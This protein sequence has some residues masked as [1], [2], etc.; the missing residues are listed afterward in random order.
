[1]PSRWTGRALLVAATA[2]LVAGLVAPAAA[3]VPTS[4]TWAA[5]L[6]VSG[7]DDTN[8]VADGAAVRLADLTPRGTSQGP[9]PAEGE[10]LLA[11]RRPAAVTDRVAVDVTADVPPAAEVIVA[12]RGTRD[13]GTWGQWTE[14]RSGEPARLSEPTVELQ[15]RVTL[16]AAPDGRGPALQRLWLTADR[17]PA[18]LVAPRPAEPFTARVF[19]TRIGLVGNDTANGH[20]VERDDRFVALPSRRALAPRG[21]GDY[22][23][24]VCSRP[25]RC[26]WAPVWDLGP[27]NTRDDHWNE[28]RQTF[29]DLPRGRPQAEAAFA[30][31]YREGRDGSGRR[32]RNP[33]GID[34]AD[35][36]FRDD[37]GL[38]D[39]AW[40]TVTYLW[41]GTGPSGSAL[42]RDAR[43]DVRAAPAADAP[44]VGVVAP[45]A[46]MTYECTT[47]TGAGRTGVGTRWIRLG[48][49]QFVQA[50]QVEVRD[51]P[52]C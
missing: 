4:E 52:S 31:G 22:T 19:A 24:R 44:V 20:E 5:E 43:L 29:G 15:V 21:S 41:T 13:D 1:M 35:G 32:V 7:G 37:L 36:T 49:A 11:P 51:V 12:V 8:V 40:V 50:D 33:A 42:D 46:R 28:Q 23:V 6:A 38:D 17:G 14:A 2:A 48:P 39:N 18:L 3:A 25:D 45:R 26:T 47:D 9:A 16:V 27:W 30:D 34:L 10:L